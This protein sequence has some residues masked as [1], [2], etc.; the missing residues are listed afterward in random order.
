MRALPVASR[1][2]VIAAAQVCV[3]TAGEL[4]IAVFNLS[5][6]PHS[7]MVHALD[8]ARHAFLA[9]RIDTRWVLCDDTAC[10]SALPADY[11][12]L[13]VM[14][15]LRAPLQ[16]GDTAHRLIDRGAG[17]PA[18][19]AMPQGFAH[20]RAYAFFDAATIVSETTVRDLS[21]VLGCILTHEAGHLLGLTHQSRG[22]M[23]PNL[24][25]ED[26][27]ALAMGRAFSLQETAQ[28][29]ARTK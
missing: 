8:T 5:G 25:P 6:A 24:Q 11:L 28:L 2:L 14:P 15:R 22:I 9:G 10:L 23:R 26:M 13:F 21:L 27:D 12:E 16:P 18:G 1:M 7:V 29:R 17:K 4:T 20:P 3:C 19:Y